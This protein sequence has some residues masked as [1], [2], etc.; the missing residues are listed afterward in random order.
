MRQHV[1]T[2][3]DALAVFV[4]LLILWQ[5][6]LWTFH[7]Q[8]FMLPSPWAVARAVGAR[9]PSLLNAL[10]ITATESGVG[11]VASIVVGVVVALFFAQSRWVRL[12]RSMRVG[13]EISRS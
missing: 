8:A 6:I 9:F 3:A 11:L 12:G 4:A 1:R 13:P 10:A 5:V 7:V 2:V